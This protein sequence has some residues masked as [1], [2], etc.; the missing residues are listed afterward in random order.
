MFKLFQS[1]PEKKRLWRWPLAGPRRA[2]GLR[3]VESLSL[4]E[5][6]FVAVIEAE[7][8]RLLIGATTQSVTL[9]AQLEPALSSAA[10]VPRVT[11]AVSLGVH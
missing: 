7:G 11:P 10:P 3:L 1:R 2:R 5:R 6:R 8:Q 4:G 9:L